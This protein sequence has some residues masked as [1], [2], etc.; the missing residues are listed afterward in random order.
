MKTQKQVIE[1]MKD[2]SVVISLPSPSQEDGVF[3]VLWAR[4]EKI[5]KSRLFCEG[6]WHIGFINDCFQLCEEGK[7]I[8]TDREFLAMP[9]DEGVTYEEIEGMLKQEPLIIKCEELKP[10]DPS[11]GKFFRDY[12]GKISREN[13]E[14]KRQVQVLKDAIDVTINDLGKKEAF[15]LTSIDVEKSLDNL[16]AVKQKAF[17]RKEIT[18]GEA[19]KQGL[20]FK[21]DGKRY[22]IIG[23][24]AKRVPLDGGVDI[25]MNHKWILENQNKK[26]KINE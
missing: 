12:L 17:P 10:V 4:G 19:I 1:A 13:K 8:C 24:T 6:L 3:G 7:A 18:M 5:N 26:V 23:G 11:E 2:K 22:N 14:L 25:S 15:K 20:D 9:Y 21:F 16:R